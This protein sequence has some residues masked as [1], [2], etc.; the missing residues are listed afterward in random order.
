MPLTI[1]AIKAAKK[2]KKPY[3]LYDE[4]GLYLSIEPTG[5]RLWRW[6]YHWDGKEK[7]LAF[8]SFPEVGLKEARGRRDETRSLLAAGIDP[9]QKKRADKEARALQAA[10]TFRAVAEEYVA[11]RERE[12]LAA[13]TLAKA[14]WLLALLAA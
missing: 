5:G 10:N 14:R 6:K 3:K 7:K 11:K 2:Q 8:G 13:V 1:A 4:K 9:G 12:G